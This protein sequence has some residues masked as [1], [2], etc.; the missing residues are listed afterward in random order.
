MPK[1]SKNNTNK[2][3]CNFCSK[4]FKFISGLIKHSS[5]CVPRQRY[6]CKDSKESLL[7]HKLWIESYNKSS[8]KTFDFLTFCQHKEYDIFSNLSV[9]CLK[10][11]INDPVDYINWCLKERFRPAEWVLETTYERY[12]RYVL[13]HEDPVHAV[14]RSLEYIKRNHNQ[15]SK[16][17]FE[18][19]GGGV[20][21]N[22]LEMGRVSPWFV[23]LSKDADRIFN[24]LNNEQLDRY[25]ELVNNNIW[26]ILKKKHSEIC[27]QLQQVLTEL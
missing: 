20:F 22:I 8:R 15:N 19:V 11:S 14:E 21:L 24:R 10:L 13:V 9:F 7:A 16:V 27:Q 1:V 3:F 6:D 17:F 4:K 23:L 2:H 5:I 26:S 25:K 18:T 12:V